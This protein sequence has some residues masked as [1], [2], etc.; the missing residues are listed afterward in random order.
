MLNTP[1][2]QG[3]WSYDKENLPEMAPPELLYVNKLIRGEMLPLVSQVL[4]VLPRY[5]SISWKNYGPKRSS[6]GIIPW[7]TTLKSFCVT[8]WNHLSNAIGYMPKLRKVILNWHYLSE[9]NLD[10]GTGTPIISQERHLKIK[11]ECLTD[12]DIRALVLSPDVGDCFLQES[13][14]RFWAELVR[15]FPKARIGEFEI[16]VAA[17]TLVRCGILVSPLIHLDFTLD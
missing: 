11:S 7:W 5:C 1:S 17:T 10:Y 16:E 4:I 3:D 2:L 12:S 14:K 15:N 6:F 9:D 13:S 8:R